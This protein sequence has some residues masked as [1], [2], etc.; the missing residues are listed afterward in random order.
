VVTVALDVNADAAKAVI[1]RHPPDHPS[2]IDQRHALDALFGVVNVPSGIWIDEDGF[3]VRPPEPAFPAPS[4]LRNAPIPEGL[5]DLVRE[6]LQEAKRIRSE[7]EKYIAALRDWV[8]NGAESRF[9]LS[10]DEVIARSRPRPEEEG[11]A[12]AHF[13]LGEHLHLAGNE[14]RAKHHW[15][16][17]HRLQPNNWTYRRQAWSLADPTQGPTEDYEGSWLADVRKVGAENYYPSLDM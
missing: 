1:E 11:L 14:K 13:E 3:I 16:E 5:P 12:A 7:P 8:A 2:L 15:R 9:A 17:A 6:M 10:P 4:P